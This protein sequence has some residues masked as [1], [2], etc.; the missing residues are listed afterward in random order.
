MKKAIDICSDLVSIKTVTPGGEEV[1]RYVSNLLDNLGFTTRHL[2]FTSKDGK[3]VVDNLYAEYCCGKGRNLGFLGHL[4]TV[5]PGD[6]WS[7]DPFKCTCIGGEMYGRG[8]ADMKGGA[9]CFLASLQ[10]TLQHVKGT[11]SVFFTCDE[12]IGSYEGTQALLDWALRN[13]KVPDHCL[14]GEPSSDKNICDRIYIGHRGSI[15]I[16]AQAGGE[17]AHSAYISEQTKNS[18]LEKLCEFIIEIKNYKFKHDDTRFPENIASATIVHSS[19]IAV[20]VI[21]GRADVNFNVRFSADYTSSDIVE[22]FRD[23]AVK[24]GISIIPKP[25]GEPYICEDKLLLQIASQSINDVLGYS[26]EYS[27]GGGT[28]DGR[29]MIKYCPVIEM[30]MVDATIHKVDEHVN[31]ADCEKLAEVYERFIELYFKD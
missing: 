1:I 17:Q 30:G 7:T 19:N 4:D 26:P 12:E 27:A 23:I 16:Q 6:G 15:N 14:I 18:A 2:V 28:S 25:S 29:F 8:I 9:G 31:A 24:Y 20:N 3:N 13:N 21:P 11:L 22:I 10:K 5:P